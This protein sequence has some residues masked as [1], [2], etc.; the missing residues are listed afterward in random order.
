MSESA[1]RARELD[2]A[3]VESTSG[4]WLLGRFAAARID[5]RLWDMTSDVGIPAYHCIVD[6]PIA[7]GGVNPIYGAGCHLSKD[8]ALSRALTEAAQSRLTFIAGSRDDLHPTLYDRTPPAPPPSL[9]RGARSDFGKRRS[10]PAGE[11]FDEDLRT[12]LGLLADAGLE[13]VV[14]VEHTRPEVEIPV[15]TVVVPGMHQLAEE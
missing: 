3:S 1:R 9:A 11:T 2:G 5:V 15:V 8:V 4:R 7:L 6:D 13:R 10:P 12:A 14:V